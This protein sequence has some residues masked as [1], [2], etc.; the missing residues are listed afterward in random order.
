MMS[1]QDQVAIVT[2]S[3]GGIGEVIAKKLASLGCHIVIN[4]I[5]AEG[6][7]RVASEI[8]EMGVRS[9]ATVGSVTKAED[10]QQM[11][12]AA[13]PSSARWISW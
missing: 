1:L 7:E 13:S 11:V 4:D 3:G 8:R 6:A 2:G 5:N 10:C 12:E 9:L